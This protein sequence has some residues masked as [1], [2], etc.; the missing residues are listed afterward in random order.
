MR[1]QRNERGAA[2]IL[3]VILVAVMSIGV[4]AVWKYLHVT[5]GEEKRMENAEAAL[6]LAEAG[7]E[8]A[9]AELRVRPDGYRG[10]IGTPLGA[11]R[12]SVEVRP[13][14]VRANYQ[15]VSRGEAGEGRFIR[16]RKTLV[17]EVALS[18]SNE[19]RRF[20]WVEEATRP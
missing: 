14:T 17:A 1:T 6:H 10:E 5:L 3:A 16:A 15:I 2:I 7:L 19:V 12:F 8:K 20:H 13:G 4:S 11:G 9:V 18:S